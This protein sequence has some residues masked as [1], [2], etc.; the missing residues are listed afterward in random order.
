MSS[1][2]G[3]RFWRRSSKDE[4]VVSH[5][6]D[7][8]SIDGQLQPEDESERG[9]EPELC[10]AEEAVEKIGC[11]LFQVLL[12]SFAGSLWV[13]H[14]LLQVVVASVHSSLYV[15]CLISTLS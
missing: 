13:S 2:R 10:T 15:Y 6:N 14:Q 3:Y 9:E 1:L 12:I 5:R 7:N 4:R 8:S 11:G